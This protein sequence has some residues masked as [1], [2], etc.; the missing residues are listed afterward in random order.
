M[1]EKRFYAVILT[2]LVSI[3][4]ITACARIKPAT[5]LPASAHPDL[6]AHTEEFRQE[7]INV[8]E[9][10]YVAVGFGLANSI[11][12]EGDDGV[13]IV[14]T[15]ESAQAAAR[16]KDAFASITDKPIKAIIYTHYHSDHTFGAKVFAGDG[17]PGIYSHESTLFYL[18]R[19]VSVTRLVT[20]TRATRQF[21]TL[22]GKGEFVNAGIGPYLDFHSTS[23]VAL[24]RPNKTFSGESMSVEIEGINLELIHAP[25]ETNDQIIVWIPEKNALICADNFYKS[26]PNLYAIRGTPYRDVTQWVKSLDKM[27]LLKPEYL[28]PCH[29]RP[30]T[31]ADEILETLTN[32]RDAIQYV[33]D[34]TIRGINNGLGPREL[35]EIVQLPPHLKNLP[36]LQ[37]YY[38]TVE[39]SVR[40]IYTGYLG[41]FDGN[42]TNLFPLDRT[43]HANKFAELAGGKESL[44]QSAR[45]AVENEEYQ[46]ALE[47]L[48]ELLV[49]D[50]GNQEV[51]GL[52][53]YCLTQLSTR[54]TAATAR[55]YY[56]TQ[57]HELLGDITIG[58]KQIT[59]KD[60]VHSVPLEAI[61]NAMAVSL[62]PEKSAAV[63]KA[64]VFRFPDVNSEYTIHV[65]KGVAE[66]QPYRCTKPD[67]I[68]TVDS[69]IWKEIAAGMRNPAI[70]VIRGDIDIEGGSFDLMRFMSLFDRN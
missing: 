10:I 1:T 3:L 29:S 70:A 55:N 54:Q 43:N 33:H 36:Y 23:T 63:D 6:A 35:V 4:C 53:A 59:E 60:V 58:K 51:S 61:F 31:G 9:G 12:I 45:A 64:V 46:W 57:A 25:G 34:Q 37:E 14:D 65:R 20:Y 16:V 41:W 47:L 22:L 39:W 28:I 21:G 18:D 69:F 32:Y 42:A 26:F 11:M 17:K 19:I 15:M 8:S 40:A 66:I 56:L 52:K 38:G 62:D 7:I 2:A 30:I 50:T 67:I 49:L 13:I 24:E 48:D 27:R 44:L 68:L 5:S